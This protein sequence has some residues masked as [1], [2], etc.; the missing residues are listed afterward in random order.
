MVPDRVAVHEPMHGE[1]NAIRKQKCF[2]C[3]P[4]YGTACRWAILGESKPK[5]PDG[6]R[7]CWELEEPKGPKGGRPHESKNLKDLKIH[8]PHVLSKFTES[9][10]DT[11]QASVQT[12]LRWDCRWL[13]RFR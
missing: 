2:L 3:S 1:L 7:L 8:V 13:C 10:D 12:C 9:P 4:F 11:Q 5:G 6:V